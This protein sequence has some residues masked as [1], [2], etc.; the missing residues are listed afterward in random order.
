MLSASLC[1]VRPGPSRPATLQCPEPIPVPGANELP[2][3]GS[4]TL[5][6]QSQWPISSEK[7]ML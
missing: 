2:A 4:V 6:H 3:L 1:T 5:L 7:E